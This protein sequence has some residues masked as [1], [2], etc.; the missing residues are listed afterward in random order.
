MRPNSTLVVKV[1]GRVRRLFPEKSS[2]GFTV[3]NGNDPF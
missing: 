2:A 1:I 3:A